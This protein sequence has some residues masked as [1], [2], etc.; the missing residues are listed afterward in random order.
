M[1]N[2][3]PFIGSSDSNAIVINDSRIESNYRLSIL[4]LDIT[5]CVSGNG[6]FI[7]MHHPEQTND[8]P[9]KPPTPKGQGLNSTP[10]P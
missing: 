10:N 9:I 8:C 5:V 2:M 4:A 7:S 1:W 6:A 3:H